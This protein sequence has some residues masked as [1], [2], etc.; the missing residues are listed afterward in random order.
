MGTGNPRSVRRIRNCVVTG[1]ELA[2]IFA[3]SSGGGGD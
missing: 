2:H 3:L 1:W